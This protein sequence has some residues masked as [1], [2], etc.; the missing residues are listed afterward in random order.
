VEAALRNLQ[1]QEIPHHAQTAEKHGV[2][3]VTLSRHHEGQQQQ[4][5]DADFEYKTTFTKQQEKSLTV[6]GWALGYRLV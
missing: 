1:S 2:D 3:R 6:T 4:R 5:S